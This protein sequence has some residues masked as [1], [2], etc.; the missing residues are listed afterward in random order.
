MSMQEVAVDVGGSVG[1][2]GRVW[3]SQMHCKV[4]YARNNGL[5]INMEVSKWL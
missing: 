3:G 1:G 4:W 5:M 2:G